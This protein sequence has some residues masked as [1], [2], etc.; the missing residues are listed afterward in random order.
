MAFMLGL[1]I[2]LVVGF[3]FAVVIATQRLNDSIKNGAL[4][5]RGKVYRLIPWRDE[6]NSERIE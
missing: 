5:C 2:G 6:T 3:I 4:E 1:L